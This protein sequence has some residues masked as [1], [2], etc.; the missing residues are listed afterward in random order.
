MPPAVI[1]P[2]IPVCAASIC[3]GM[4]A[5]PAVISADAS[6]WNGLALVITPPMAVCASPSVKP[7]SC[8]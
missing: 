8:K 6:S 3:P 7:A 1:A 5:A 2:A 4:L